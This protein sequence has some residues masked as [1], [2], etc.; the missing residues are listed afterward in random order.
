[1]TE[2][3]QLRVLAE[4]DGDAEG[5]KRRLLDPGKITVSDRGVVELVG[6][7]GELFDLP[8]GRWSLHLVVGATAPADVAELDAGGPWTVVKPPYRVDIVP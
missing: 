8:T 5:S 1:M 3:L 7:F 4:A 2:S 6:T